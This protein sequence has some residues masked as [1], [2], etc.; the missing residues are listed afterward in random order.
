MKDI[1]NVVPIVHQHMM[2][3]IIRFQTYLRYVIEICKST[4]FC[5]QGYYRT[6]DNQCVTAADCC[7]GKYEQ[8]KEC[9]SACIE[10]CNSVP[11]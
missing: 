3:L 5:K 8:Y 9:D 4:C 2:I 1:N 11:E 10:T 7:S 6:K